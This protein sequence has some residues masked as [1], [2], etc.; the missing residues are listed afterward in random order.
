MAGAV[1]FATTR[2]LDLNT[3]NRLLCPSCWWQDDTARQ[4]LR[5]HTSDA[6]PYAIGFT[7]LAAAVGAARLLTTKGHRVRLGS[8]SAYTVP[9]IILTDHVTAALLALPAIQPLG[10]DLPEHANNHWKRSA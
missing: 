9:H 2:M 7:D 10:I 3:E 1:A 8:P 5:A 4:E 6:F